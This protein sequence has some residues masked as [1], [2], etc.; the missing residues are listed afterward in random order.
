MIQAVDQASIHIN[1]INGEA[2]FLP[3]TGT[4]MGHSLAAGD[5]IDI[6][7]PSVSEWNSYLGEADYSYSLLRGQCPISKA[8]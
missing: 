8:T 1:A 2:D 3:Q 7:S 5:F 4:T 6:Y